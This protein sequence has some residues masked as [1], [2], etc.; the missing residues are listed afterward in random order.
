M[1]GVVDD[2]EKERWG[3]S[4]EVAFLVPSCGLGA[5]EVNC[6]IGIEIK[7]GSIEEAQGEAKQEG[8]WDEEADVEGLIGRTGGSC[9]H[10]YRSAFMMAWTGI[11]RD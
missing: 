3:G 6:F 9:K 2:K 7:G 5:A 10:C 1:L 11:A 4:A 8:T